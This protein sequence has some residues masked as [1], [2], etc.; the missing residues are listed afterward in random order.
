MTNKILF[1]TEAKCASTW[2][3]TQKHNRICAPES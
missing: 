1:I 3:R 2:A